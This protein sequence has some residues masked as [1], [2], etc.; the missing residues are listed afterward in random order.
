MLGM[1]DKVAMFLEADPAQVFVY[2][3]HGI[4]V[5]YFPVIRG[6]QEIAELLLARGAAVDGEEGTN[7]L[8]G[9][10]MFRQA[11]MLEWLL[12]H[13]ANPQVKDYEGKTPLERA[14]ERGDS[15][16]QGMLERAVQSRSP[17]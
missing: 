15:Q 16:I 12:A 3:A 1:Q 17:R 9:A 2:G 7:P 6:N 4:L 8:Q 11:A 5:L 13:G 10:V 14:K